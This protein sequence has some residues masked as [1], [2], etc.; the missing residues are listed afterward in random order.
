MPHVRS[1]F[2][3]ENSVGQ[4]GNYVTE[5]SSEMRACLDLRLGGQPGQY[6]L[7]PCLSMTPPPWV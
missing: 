1:C 6:T 4:P 2:S 3:F 7:A 5:V